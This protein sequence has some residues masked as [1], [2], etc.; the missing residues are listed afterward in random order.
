[1]IRQK[2]TKD[3]FPMK[4]ALCDDNSS[5][6]NTLNDAI[7]QHYAYKDWICTIH[8]F[9]SPEALLSADLSSTQVVFL[10]IDMPHINGLDVAK[11][12]RQDYP[13]LLVVFVTGH[14][15][16]APAGYRVNAFRYLLKNELADELPQCLDE[17]WE[18]LFV[19]Q[20]SLPIQQSEQI[21]HTRLIDIIYLEGTPLR[22]VLLHTTQAQ[23]PIQE[24]IGKLSEYESQLAHRGFLRIQKSYLVNM[25]H[26]VKIKS[27]KATLDTGEVLSVSEQSYAQICQKFALWKGQRL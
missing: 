6:V 27:Y 18:I 26:I 11:R 14:I 5:F 21:V 12:L 4:F 25:S 8:R 19:Q 17:I 23:K 10:D 13:G 15:K 22:R 3:V 7:I 2:S 20:E 1:M 24:C 16:Y 9:T